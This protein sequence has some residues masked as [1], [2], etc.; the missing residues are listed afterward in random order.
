M[1]PVRMLSVGCRDRLWRMGLYARQ[2][3]RGA[4]QAPGITITVLAAVFSIGFPL[5]DW[6]LVHASSLLLILGVFTAVLLSLA[7]SGVIALWT[8]DPNTYAHILV[9]GR[10]ATE[11]LF[12]IS[13]HIMASCHRTLED[14]DRAEK[15]STALRNTIARDSQPLTEADR[16]PFE[17]LRGRLEKTGRTLHVPLLRIEAMKVLASL[18]LGIPQR[19]L[20]DHVFQYS[21]LMHRDR[22]Q[23]YI[24]IWDELLDLLRSESLERGRIPK[25]LDRSRPFDNNTRRRV[26]FQNQILSH[27]DLHSYIVQFASM[28]STSGSLATYA[29]ALKSVA[30]TGIAKLERARGDSDARK[31]VLAEIED[32]FLFLHRKQRAHPGFDLH[33][34][35]RRALREIGSKELGAAESLLAVLDENPAEPRLIKSHVSE[36]GLGPFLD[37]PLSLASLVQRSRR[38]IAE[39]LDTIYTDWFQGVEQRSRY[40]V[41]HGLSQTVLSVLQWVLSRRTA[42]GFRDLPRIFFLLA[43]EEDSFDTRAMEYELKENRDVRDRLNLAAG[44]ESHLLGLLGAG[45]AVL[46]L[47]GAECFDAEKRVVHPRGIVHRLARLVPRLA[48]RNIRVLVVV[49]AEH[50]KL[51]D[52]RLSEDTKFYS[53]HFD[54]IDLYQPGWIDVIVTDRGTVP[55]EWQTAVAGTGRSG[56]V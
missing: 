22:L 7:V 6:G 29:R 48:R 47:L 8:A 49:V 38:E 17:T 9:A 12:V 26:R 10:P 54:R 13:C 34:L 39:R 33:T 35:L 14:L 18:E 5:L 50:Y 15:L 1:M 23:K 41:S 3:I 53:Q 24:G 2:R 16:G 31:R 21:P 32:R 43:E 45:D 28:H 37:V 51:H 25:V 40:I 27:R 4:I 19:R 20:C 30:V 36:Q 56:V 46:V 52:T 11:M 42:P 55:A 44:S